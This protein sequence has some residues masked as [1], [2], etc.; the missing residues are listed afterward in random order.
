MTTLGEF[1]KT[2]ERL[3]SFILLFYFLRQDVTL[4]DGEPNPGRVEDP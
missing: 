3:N 1:L 4:P 2:N